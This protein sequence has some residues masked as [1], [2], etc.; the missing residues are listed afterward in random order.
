MKKKHITYTVLVSLYVFRACGRSRQ[1]FQLHFKTV[2]LD[3]SL[4]SP[5]V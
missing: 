5:V 2:G 3:F 4:Q 1:P